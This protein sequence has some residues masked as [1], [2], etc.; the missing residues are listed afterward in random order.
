MKVSFLLADS[1]RN[2]QFVATGVMPKQ[3]V[4]I[5]LFPRDAT[6]EQRAEILAL[7]INDPENNHVDFW[8]Y[9]ADGGEFGKYQI[10]L[11][12]APDWAEAIRLIRASRESEAINKA[13]KAI[14]NAKIEEKRA[15]DQAMMER[16]RAERIA[17]QDAAIAEKAAWCAAHGSD[18]LRRGVAAGYDCG[19]LYVI[20]RAA[21]E[22]PGYIVD[23][24]D[25]ADWKDRSCPSL[26]ALNEADAISEK[27]GKPAQVVWL[28]DEPLA[29]KRGED[30]EYDADGFTAGEAVVVLDYL[31]KRLAKAL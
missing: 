23:Y 13:A 21:L 20:E 3:L 14:K 19:R 1:V 7:G 27:L 10:A 22:A 2:A 11:E 29:Q 26:A 17:A 15:A 31:G 30:W 25:H 24:E 5:E 8:H 28:T 6:P 18:Q 9:P 12:S 16:V 4:T